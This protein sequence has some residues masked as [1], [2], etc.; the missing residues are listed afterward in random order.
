VSDTPTMGNIWIREVL[1]IVRNCDLGCNC[2]TVPNV[3]TSC[4]TEYGIDYYLA[5]NAISCGVNCGFGEYKGSGT[6]MYKCKTCPPSCLTCTGPG[7]DGDGNANQC[8][9]CKNN[10]TH[11]YYLQQGT[12]TCS[13]TACLG[14]QFVDTGN[15]CTNCPTGCAVCAGNAVTNGSGTR[16]TACSGTYYLQHGTTTCSVGCTTGYYNGTGADANKCLQCDSTCASCTDGTTQC[17]T[18]ASG[19]PLKQT[20][21][22]CVASCLGNQFTLSSDCTDCPTGCAACTGNA[23]TGGSGTQCTA[24]SGTYYLQHGTT[25]C[26]VGCT[27]GYYNGTGADANK[28]LQ[29]DST[30]ASCTDGTTQ[31]TT[32][33]SGTPLKQ[34]DGTCVASCLGNQFTLSSDC[35][36]C[37]TGCAACTGNAVTGGSGTQ[38]TACSGTYYLQ[39]GTTTCSVGCTT[40]YYNGTGADANKCLQCDSTCASCTDGTTQCTTCASGTPL[41]QTDGTCVA[42]CLGN[43]FTLSSNC[44]N[45]PPSCS[46]CTGAGVDGD[47]NANQCQSCQNDGDSDYY[48]QQGTTTCSITACLGTQFVATGNICTNCPTGCAVCTGNAVTDGS[49]TQCTACSGT[50][51]LQHGTTTCSVG[52]TTGYYN[53]TGADANKCLQ[54]D[55]TCASCTDG[56]TQCTTCASGT[57]LKQTDGTCVAS[58]LGNQFTLSSDCTDCPTGCAAL[59]W[60]RGNWWIWDTMHSLLW[61]ILPPAWHYHVLCG[62]HNR[63]LQRN[64]SGCEQMPSV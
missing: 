35:T 36:D 29:C 8:Q 21:G 4:K 33:A 62:M 48:L 30:C 27:T 7:V 12:T 49:G 10:G 5:T 51:Y 24:C 3:C 31:C 20:D 37:P 45:C 56:T 40:G 38:C 44:V 53:G 46:T 55:S 22:T 43:Q 26:S 42:S 25:T 13:I 63:I 9:M 11:D 59:H 58:C 50:Y 14:T 61:D 41:K 1:V 39:H 17:T 32:C 54:C 23:V 2:L 28:C 16:C 47:G 15:V 64:R 60:K 19:T 57:P 52:C 6:D 18:C 34:T